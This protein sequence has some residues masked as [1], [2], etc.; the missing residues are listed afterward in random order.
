MKIN[1]N[2]QQK[3]G[4]YVLVSTLVIYIVVVLYISLNAKSHVLDNSEELINSYV[5][6]AAK[7]IESDLERNLEIVKTLA[8]AYK[9]YDEM[10]TVHWKMLFENMYTNVFVGN[11]DIY[12]LWDSW[13]YRAIAP[14][15]NRD[16]ERMTFSI[17]ESEGEISRTWSSRG[18]SDAY[19]ELK[20]RMRE[21]IAE[22]YLD[23]F[24]EGKQE[25]KLM[26][27]V[28]A[29][30]IRDDEY[31]GL[32]GIDITLDEIEEM[33]SEINPYEGSFAYM[34]SNKGMCIGH[35]KLDKEMELLSKI[36][37][38]EVTNNNLLNQIK[39]GK[40]IAYYST[41]EDGVERYI[42]HYPIQVGKTKTPW[43][44][45]ISIP[46][47][48][49]VEES[50]TLL[51]TG[52]LFGFIG[53]IIIS[54]IIWFVSRSISG[55]IV[56]ITNKLKEIAKGKTEFED[57]DIVEG[58]EI[59]EMRRALRTSLKG[60]NEK[61]AFAMEIG[62]GNLDA[63]VD[64]LGEEDALGKSLID[65]RESLIQAKKDEEARMSEDQKRRWA[66]EGVALFADILRKHN[67]DLSELT[68]QVLKNM[69]KYL[70]ANQGGIFILNDDNPDHL[71]FELKSA[72][73]FDRKKYLEKKI[74]FG[75]GMVGN[76]AL[77]KEKIY[78]TEVPQDY[79]EITSGL[80]D[81]NPSALLLI[82]LITDEK[83]MGVLE[84]A[85]FKEF[86]PHEID[87]IEKV[88]ES[89]ASTLMGAKINETTKE[90]L[91]RTQ[92]QAEEMQA[93]EEEM[94]QNMEEMMATQEEANRR[95]MDLEEENERLKQELEEL[96][97]QLGE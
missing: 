97:Q 9:V 28:V 5:K 18:T 81:S 55:P 76:C 1:L 64:L 42:V 17:S 90:L 22:P 70:N 61:T 57:D 93:Q 38:E 71:F 59:G 78:L 30:V 77:E 33:I 94:R 69:I 88:G 11:N 32:I 68:F 54:L 44:L 15:L 2:I 21:S 20:S 7:D 31:I 74:E 66:N 80:G 10:D 91:D 56:K 50:N 49:I 25:R 37:P 35:D 27:S 3:I 63:S 16:E 47:R 75:V 6:D 84:I 19:E 12:C 52:M 26:T 48:K 13:E 36:I 86:E 43:S 23:N 29:P 87:F 58:G 34:V 41:D 40:Q 79:I 95:E 85:S 24:T 39:A 82:P 46:K 51:M 73:A 14:D 45:A 8:N 60:L 92:E 89:V 65:M 53:L 4:L 72:Y 67:N 83:V 62:K 96:R